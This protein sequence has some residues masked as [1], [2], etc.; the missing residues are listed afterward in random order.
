MSTARRTHVSNTIGLSRLAAHTRGSQWRCVTSRKSVLASSGE[1]SAP[2]MCVACSRCSRSFKL[3]QPWQPP[4]SLPPSGDGGRASPAAVLPPAG[5]SASPLPPPAPA[6]PCSSCA[7][8]SGCSAT[9][10][11][12]GPQPEAARCRSS[13]PPDPAA[14]AR[15]IA[16]T[17]ATPP[18][19]EVLPPSPPSAPVPSLSLPP[20]SE[21]LPPSPPASRQWPKTSDSPTTCCCTTATTW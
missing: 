5:S 2:V 20:P 11:C 14:W 9:G 16:C 7:A 8:C 17:V 6:W 15:R 12:C 1:K 4:P 13:S 3:Q 18:A 21:V 19:S 10:G